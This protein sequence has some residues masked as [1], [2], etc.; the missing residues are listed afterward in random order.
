MSEPRQT[1]WML[2]IGVVIVLL[3]LGYVM[4]R[5][6]VTNAANTAKNLAEQTAEGIKSVLNITPRV[7]INGLT[8]IQQTSPILE[9]ALMQQTLFKEYSWQHTYIGST[10]TLMLRGEFIAKAGFDLHE[11]FTIDILQPSSG[12]LSVQVILPKPRLLSLE[13]KQYSVAKDESGFWNFITAEDREHAVNAMQHEVRASVEQ[14][15]MMERVKTEMER[16]IREIITQ[17]SA[18]AVSNVRIE[19]PSL[20]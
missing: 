2:R 10:K 8:V 5:S 20:Q 11:S 13:M 4:I 7:T 6:I 17:R 3:V 16:R 19:Y 14:S 12:E 1:R 15:D 18:G 9:L